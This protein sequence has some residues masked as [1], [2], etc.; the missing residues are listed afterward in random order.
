MHTQRLHHL[1]YHP[2]G[3]SNGPSYIKAFSG[4]GRAE[5]TYR[6]LILDSTLWRPN[7]L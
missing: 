4:D 2:P 6:I 7:S 1:R 3:S 5:T